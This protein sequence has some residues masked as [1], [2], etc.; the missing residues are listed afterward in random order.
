[1]KKIKSILA[2]VVCISV[3]A[4]FGTGCDLTDSS[5]SDKGIA[6]VNTGTSSPESDLS[7]KEEDSSKSEDVSSSIEE[8]SKDQNEDVTITE[9]VIVDQDGVVVTAKEISKGIWG[10]ELKVLI[11]NNTDK[12]LTFQ[13]RNASVNG[14]MAETMISED[15]AAGKRSNTEVTFSSKGLKACGIDTFANIELSF[16]IFTSDDWETYLDT[17]PITIETSASSDYIQEIDDSGKVL[18]D[19]NGIKIIGKS[20]STDDS[21]FGPGLVLYIEN[22]SNQNIT[23]QARDT[24]VNGFMIDTSMSEDVLVGKKS[25]TALTF[26]SSS[27]EENDITDIKTVETSFHVFDAESWNTIIDTD[28][29]TMEFE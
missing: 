29:I 1:M 14:F 5:S 12:D 21:V 16:H 9:T 10:P 26:F 11:E 28:T 13:V 24:S 19:N 20:L 7:S 22:N 15:V 27:L 4:V 3:F 23:V 2:L 8:T 17:A 18:Y 6:N 25:I